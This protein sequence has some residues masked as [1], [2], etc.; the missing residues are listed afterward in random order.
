MAWRANKQDIVTILAIEAKLLII[1][2]TAKKAIYL[3]WLMQ[4]LNLIISKVLTIKYD[5]AQT[6]QLLVDKSMKL[7][8]NFWYVNIHLHWLRQEGQRGL[9]HIWWASTKE[10]FANGLTKAL[11]S[12]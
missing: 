3:F 8:T 6:I 2:Q 12:A 5:N 11:A 1:L 10:M 4:A 7:Q 9:I